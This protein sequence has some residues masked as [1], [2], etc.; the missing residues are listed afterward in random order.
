MIILPIEIASMASFNVSWITRTD[1]FFDTFTKRIRV[2]N[3]FT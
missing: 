1:R 3:S 2:N